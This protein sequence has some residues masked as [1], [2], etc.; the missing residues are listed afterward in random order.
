[1]KLEKYKLK[2]NQIKRLE[3]QK[4]KSLGFI[5]DPDEAAGFLNNFDPNGTKNILELEKIYRQI[6]IT[7]GDQLKKPVTPGIPGSGSILPPDVREGMFAGYTK[8]TTM[9][10]Y[11]LAEDELGLKRGE[12]SGLFTSAT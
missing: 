3:K 6:D 9:D 10:A 7:K 8:P 2:G 4:A 11:N 5:T 1:M 12:G